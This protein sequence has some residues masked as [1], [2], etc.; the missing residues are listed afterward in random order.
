[1]MK[2][3]ALAMLLLAALL[4][5]AA[6]AE[7]PP[8]P[9]PTPGEATGLDGAAILRDKCADACHSTERVDAQEL[10]AVGWELVIERMRTNGANLTDDEATA[11]AEYLSWRE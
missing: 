3:L 7:E 4:T 10:D 11:L 5:L 8:V 2:R 1:M 6:C 9:P